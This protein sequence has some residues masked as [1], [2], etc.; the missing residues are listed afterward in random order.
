[1]RLRLAFGVSVDSGILHYGGKAMS[2]NWAAEAAE[3]L[4]KRQQTKQQRDELLLEKRRLFAEQG[5][6]LWDQV[7]ER[8]TSECLELNE[9]RGSA[10]V[11]VKDLKMGELDVR[12][13][14]NGVVTK[15]HCTFEVTSSQKALNWS[16]SDVVRGNKTKRDNTGGSCSLDVSEAGIVV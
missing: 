11:Y 3:K 4:R 9:K 1:M 6:N 12:F 16:Y 14:F 15:L 2:S 5:P 7:R 8:V 10:V 13:E